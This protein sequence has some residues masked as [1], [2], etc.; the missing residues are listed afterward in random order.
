M[1]ADTGPCG[2]CTEIFYDHGA[3]IPG[4]PPGSPDEDGD[5][6]I[7]IWNLVFMQF[8]RAADG[9]LSKLPA[10]CVDTGMGLERLAAVLQH[11]HSNYEIDLFQH[12]IKV[13]GKLTNTT[14]LENKSLRV[15]ADHIRACSFLIVDGVMPS[16]EGRGYVLRR[17]IRRAVR[18][19]YKLGQSQ[20]FFYQ[21]VP[22][23]VVAMGEAF[24]ELA[25]E[26]AQV[27]RILKLEE[28]RFA[29]TLCA[30]MVQFDARNLRCLAREFRKR[31]AH[32]Y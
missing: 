12:L 22:A 10:P 4:G 20:P 6:F 11:V 25:R 29:E 28:E 2:P 21:L 8:D 9:T 27:A 1:M 24:P 13:A 14:D 30:G 26:A 15:I 19:G 17:I 3:H 5:R 32:R 18:H 16:N 7:E 23:L 31:F